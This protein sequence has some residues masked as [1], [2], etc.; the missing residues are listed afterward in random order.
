AGMAAHAVGDQPQPQ[1]AVTVIGVLIELAAQA[2]MAEVSEFDHGRPQGAVSSG[3]VFHDRVRAGARQGPH[4]AVRWREKGVGWAGSAGPA[5]RARSG[6]L[7]KQLV[8]AAKASYHSQPGSP[9][10]TGKV[11]EWLNVPDSKSGIR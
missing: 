8:R 10:T 3:K 1:F 4:R 7:Q 2:D 11:A 9:G 6:G 5:G